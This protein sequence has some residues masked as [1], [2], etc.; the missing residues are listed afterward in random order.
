M[1]VA[2]VERSVAFS[3]AVGDEVVGRVPETPLGALTTLALPG[4]DFVTM[5]LVHDPAAVGAGPGAER[6]GAPSHF[7]IQVESMDATLADLA[8]AG[9]D[10][11]PP[12]SPDGIGDFL[13]AGI[14]DPDGNR[15]ELV[16]WPDGHV[17]G[18]TAAD[19]AGSPGATPPSG[20][21]GRRR[22]AR[23]RPRSGARPARRSGT[24]VPA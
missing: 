5:E 10:A 17:A 12:A 24:P 14:V 16:Q 4:D 20:T 18:M 3:T 1:G 22:G 15:I 13:T 19:F 6:T 8:A 2:D 11:E 21:S 9:I 23:R 7:V